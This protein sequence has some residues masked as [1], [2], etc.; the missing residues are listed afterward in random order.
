M[1][2][3]VETFACVGVPDLTVDIEYQLHSYFIFVTA[4]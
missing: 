4:A 3:G 2:K 1:L